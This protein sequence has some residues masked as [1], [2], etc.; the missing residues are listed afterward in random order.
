MLKYNNETKNNFTKKKNITNNL[1]FFTKTLQYL[2]V[3]WGKR[4][5]SFI[6]I[7]NTIS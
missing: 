2:G 4:N 1:K 7:K 3:F 5:K 6:E